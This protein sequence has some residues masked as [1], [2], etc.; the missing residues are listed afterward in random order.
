VREHV[1]ACKQVPSQTSGQLQRYQAEL[2]NY[3]AGIGAEVS[4]TTPLGTRDVPVDFDFS[5]GCP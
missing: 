5:Y 1:P 3:S 4:V 2:D